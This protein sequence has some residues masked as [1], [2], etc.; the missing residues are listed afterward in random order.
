MTGLVD[1]SKGATP[2]TPEEREGLIPSHVALHSELNELEQQN[3]LDADGWAFLRK[4][5]PVIEPFGRS[6]HRRMFRDVWRWAGTYRTSEKN[7][8][9]VQW[10]LV[11]PRLYDVLDQTRYWIENDTFSADEIAVRFHYALVSTHSFPNGNGRWSRL[12]GDILAVNL[13]QKRFT[14]GGRTL[15]AAGETRDAYIAT[16]KAADNH[17][18]TRLLPFARS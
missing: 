4:R 3:I 18:F 11:Q 6:L 9:N 2:L 17:D 13:G 10:Q 8:G 15:R 7:I 12:M 16:L 5:N 1:E 14:W